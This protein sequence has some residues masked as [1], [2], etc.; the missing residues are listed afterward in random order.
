LAGIMGGIKSEV[1]EKTKTIILQGAIFDPV[2][3]RRASKHLNHTTDASYRYERGVDYEGTIRG[4]EMAAK[5]IQEFSGAKVGE[6]VD[7]I[8]QKRALTKIELNLG[9]VNKLLGIEI[10]LTAAKEFL[11]RLNFNVLAVDSRL[12][13][14]VPSFR[15]FDVK[16]WQDLAEEIARMYGYNQIK[17]NYFD[18]EQSKKENKDWIKRES[19]KDILSNLGLTEVYS[20]S[21]AEKK[22]IELSGDK[23]ADC[24][25]MASPLSPETQFL[26]PSILPSLLKAI[27]KNPWAPEANIFEIEKV[28]NQE[29]EWWQLG[30]ATT[31]KKDSLLIKALEALKVKD[32]IQTVDQKILDSYKIRR[33]VKYL[34]LDLD[35]IKWEFTDYRL[36]ASKNQYR[37]ISKFPPTVRD[38]AFIVEDKTNTQ[39]VEN[40]IKTISN[41]ILIVELFDEFSSDK[42]GKGKKNVAYHIWLQDLKR[43]ME[44]KE[45]E[46]IIDKIIQ[47][48][49]NKYNAKLRK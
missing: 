1:D 9:K 17:R 8:S 18:K 46:E 2:L 45:V 43:P 27:A 28:F 15:V 4:V 13:V 39:A 10:N 35:D 47:E 7:I 20:Y 42:F 21:F 29:K 32:Q 30:M 40:V 19:I 6:S 44:E 33:P 22:E 11:E 49:E 38:L 31:G 36:E 14:S 12:M 48:V 34:I 16:I 25:E 37:P 24:V 23:I 41:Q 26:R 3:I 5:L